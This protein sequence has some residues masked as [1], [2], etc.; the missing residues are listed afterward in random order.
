[1]RRAALLLLPLALVLAACGGSGGSKP[2][3]SANTGSGQSPQ[4]D[5][6]YVNTAIAKSGKTPMHA[7]VSGTVSASGQRVSMS[8]SADV[9][10]KSR[11]G[12]MHMQMGLAGQQIPLEEVLDGSTVYASSEFFSSFLPSGKK[13]LKLTVSSASSLGAAGFALT[14]QPGSVPPLKDVRKVG[15][16]TIGGVQTT[17]YAGSVDE[18]KLSRAEKAALART[19]AVFGAV[20]VWVGADGYVHKVR[21]VTT[22]SAGGKKASIVVISTMSNYGEKVHVTVPPASQ[23]LDA[24]KLD[25]PGFSA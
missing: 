8:G 11:L 18:T 20:D 22:S 24:A 16:A 1:M 4:V 25:I 19:H 7:V 10:P 3:A 21:V 5:A 13:W 2:A 12:T 17:E 9:D 14:S 23:T 6:S 15:T